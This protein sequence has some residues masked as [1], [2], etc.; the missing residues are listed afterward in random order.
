MILKRAVAKLRAQ[1]WVAISIELAIV[2]LGV[3]IGIQVANWNEARHERA[4]GDEYLE[5][6]HSDLVAD[7]AALDRREVFWAD[8]VGYGDA[9]LDFAES[10]KLKDG[11]AWKTLL[12]FYQASQIWSY[13]TSDGTY[14]ELIAAG[15]L[16]LVRNPGLRSA[17]SD[18]Y[19]TGGR[20]LARIADVIP[21]YREEVRGLT[22]MRVQRHIWAHCHRNRSGDHQELID[23][24]APIS[25]VEARKI[26]A[27]YLESPEVLK[28]LRF[29]MT[30]LA[31][32]ANLAR[33]DQD[34]AKHLAARVAKETG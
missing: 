20:R 25:E 2:I 12:A 17:L 22:P 4:R 10:G 11:S 31:V 24:D 21:A 18:Y 29:W 15:D 7:V 27:S 26:L 32:T 33:L 9:A 5:R 30:N 19:V 16:G 8:V 23:C 6:I 1:D 14:R 34:E 3:F 13:T 28:G